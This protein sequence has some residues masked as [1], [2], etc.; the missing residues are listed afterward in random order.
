M[1]AIFVEP[2]IIV[3]RFIEKWLYQ[4][5]KENDNLI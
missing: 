4:K 3:Q 5:V 1:R 2:K